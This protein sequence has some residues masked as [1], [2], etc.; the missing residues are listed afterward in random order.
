MR[1]CVFHNRVRLITSS[2]IV[3]F[4]H[5]LAQIIIMTRQ[6]VACKNHVATPK[7]KVTVNTLT[8]C[9]GF[10]KTCTV[11]PITLYCMVEF[12]RY[13]YLAYNA[14]KIVCRKNPAARPKVNVTVR[15]LPVC[16]GSGET[17]L[18]PARYFV[19]HCGI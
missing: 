17:C 16:E 14:D 1:V 4:K 19:L 18:C 15:T 3:A 6:C 12:E 8:L 13:I 11:R 5:N 7:V 9:I 2:S 10:S